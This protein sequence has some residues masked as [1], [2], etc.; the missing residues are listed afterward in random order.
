M[1]TKITTRYQHSTNIFSSDA[2]SFTLLEDSVMLKVK[3]SYSPLIA[4]TGEV[5]GR[6]EDLAV[7]ALTNSTPRG[8][9]A[10]LGAAN[11]H[12]LLYVKFMGMA[13]DSDCERILYSIE[14]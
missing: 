14:L 11:H 7:S 3:P 5:N 6:V 12:D 1:I 9:S 4:A 8:P 13:F 2:G 10:T